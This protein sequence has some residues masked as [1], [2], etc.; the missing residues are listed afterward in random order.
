MRAKININR[1][2]HKVEGN[3]V[4]WF[5]GAKWL[6]KETCNTAKKAE[7]LLNEV[8]EKSKQAKKVK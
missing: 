1:Q 4:L 6:I 2:P 5:N 3:Q 7:D 8:K